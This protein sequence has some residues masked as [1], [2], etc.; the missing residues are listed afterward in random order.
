MAR[1]C[2]FEQTTHP[3]S[4]TVPDCWLCLAFRLSP[5]CCRLIYLQARADLSLLQTSSQPPSHSSVPSLS[6]HVC[7]YE[8]ARII[9]HPLWSLMG[10]ISINI[11]VERTF[12][13]PQPAFLTNPFSW[14]WV[15]RGGLH[16][17]MT[18]FL[19]FFFFF[20]RVAERQMSWAPF[21]WYTAVAVW[22]LQTFYFVKVLKSNRAE[23][24]MRVKEPG[25]EN[26]DLV[27]THE[28]RKC[29]SWL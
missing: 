10:L 3:N 19:F 16:N 17:F 20:P 18:V 25:R 24:K 7:V 6:L 26:D 5:L 1:F 11:T 2:V 8:R 29:K 4:A 13:L 21:D 22:Q 15:Q 27:E 23:G 9:A 12:V 28:G 14:Q